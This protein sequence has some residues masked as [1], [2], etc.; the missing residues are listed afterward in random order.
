MS[1]RFTIYPLTLLFSI[2]LLVL[3]GYFT[4]PQRNLRS[5]ARYAALNPQGSHQTFSSYLKII[6]AKGYILVLYT[7][8]QPDFS[9]TEYITIERLHQKLTIDLINGA[10]P[11]NVSQ[12]K[13]EQAAKFLEK[14]QINLETFDTLTNLKN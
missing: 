1:K 10:G 11:D 7:G 2:I 9:P 14:H 3:P 5:A 8:N 6:P 4:N 13:E 12:L